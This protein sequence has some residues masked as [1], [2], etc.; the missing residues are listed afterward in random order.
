[1]RLRSLCLFVLLLTG[2]TVVHAPPGGLEERIAQR[3]MNIIG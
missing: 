2:V 3:I 1:M